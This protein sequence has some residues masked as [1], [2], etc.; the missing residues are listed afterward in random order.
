MG[1]RKIAREGIYRLAQYSRILAELGASGKEMICSHDL[2]KMIGKTAAQVRRDLAC[3]GHFGVRGQ[4]YYIRDLS[5]E[6]AKIMGMDRECNIALIGAGNLGPALLAHSALRRQGFNIVAVFDSHPQKIGEKWEEIEIQDIKELERIIGSKR[7]EIAIIAVAGPEAGLIIDRLAA[8][9]LKAIL[10]V[11][12]VQLEAPQDV[13]L[14]NVD[15][16]IGLEELSY[17]IRN[18]LDD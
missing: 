10:N 14:K 5:R 6:I 9:G 12:P 8:A 3:F 17:S 4:G 13:S 15:L 1:T 2:A 18:I 11:A 7:I 16:S